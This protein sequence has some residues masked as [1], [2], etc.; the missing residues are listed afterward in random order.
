VYDTQDDIDGRAAAVEADVAG[1]YPPHVAAAAS[2]T[3]T[4]TIVDDDPWPDD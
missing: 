3:T 4:T 2:A 1:L